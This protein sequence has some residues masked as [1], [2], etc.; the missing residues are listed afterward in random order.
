MTNMLRIL[1]TAI[2]IAVGLLQASATS[3]SEIDSLLRVL[4][5]VIDN[6]DMY[7]AAKEKQLTTL[8]NSL[9]SLRSEREVYARNSEIIDLYESFVCDSAK[10]YLHKNYRIAERLRDSSLMAET[11][12]RLALVYAM[13]GQFVQARDIF[14][15][16]DYNSFP[17]HI[18]ARYGWAQLKYLEN[19]MISTDEPS[20][21]E[22]FHQERMAWRDSLINMFDVNSDLYRKEI[23]GRCQEIGNYKA[24]L[25]IYLDIFHGEQPDTHGY[26]MV[27]KGLA[28]LY[29]QL[30]DIEQHKRYLLLSSITDTRLAVKENESLMALA[31]MLYSE[32]RWIARI[33]TC[34]WLLRTP[35]SI[36]QDSKMP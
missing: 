16:L 27:S 1:A 9:P 12:I 15:S 28:D 18:K 23:A 20:Q 34:E 26:A 2:V 3:V 29:D 13:S 11:S 25:T 35:T 10:V 5:N 32:G 30:G 24:A 17:G 8:K 22:E 33:V 14:R 19:M 36:I 21:R 7:L 31:E 6:R 4:D